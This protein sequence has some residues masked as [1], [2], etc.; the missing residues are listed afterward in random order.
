VQANCKLIGNCIAVPGLAV[1]EVKREV[2]L[3]APSLA[4]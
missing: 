3:T 2:G 4:A 1:G